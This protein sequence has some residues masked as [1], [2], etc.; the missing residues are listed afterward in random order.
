MRVTSSGSVPSGRSR[1]F[2][3]LGEIR[4]LDRL[5]VLEP[6]QRL[7]RLGIV[8]ELHFGHRLRHVKQ[9]GPEPHNAPPGQPQQH[10]RPGVGGETHQEPVFFRPILDF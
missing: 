4:L 9:Y 1:L 2:V 5:L 8:L 10:L 3:R 6:E 7:A